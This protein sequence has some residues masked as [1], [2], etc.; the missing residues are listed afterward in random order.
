MRKRKEDPILWQNFA[1][2]RPQ[3]NGII[4]VIKKFYSRG[5]WWKITHRGGA[6]SMIY[7]VILAKGD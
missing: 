5:N 3:Q 6:M 2:V 4:M 7:H 1:N